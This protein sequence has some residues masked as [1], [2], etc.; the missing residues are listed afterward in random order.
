M[1]IKNIYNELLLEYECD[2]NNLRS[3]DLIG[4][5]L[6]GADLPIYCKWNISVL[7][8]KIK[9]GCKTKTIEEWDNWF[10]SDEIFETKRNT[11]DFTRIYANYVAVREYCKIINNIT[12]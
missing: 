10:N 6:T 4:A 8:K 12:L 7:D 11:E 9:I 2:N 3:A 5:D 1:I